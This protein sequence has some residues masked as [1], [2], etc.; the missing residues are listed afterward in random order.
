MK[1]LLKEFEDLKTAQFI[2]I[3]E[4]HSKTTGEVAN[5]VLNAGFKYANA[6]QKDLKA[7]QSATNEDIKAIASDIFDVELVKKAI[8]K[9]TASLVK[10]QNSETQSNQ[11]KAQQDAYF[12]ITNG[13]KLHKETLKVHVYALHVSKKVI[14]PGEYKK[15]NSRELTLAQNAVK[16]YFNFSTSKY[17]Q[18]IVD[19]KHLTSKINISGNSYEI[20]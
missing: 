2:G 17:R 5:H 8:E 16:K 6:V 20:L 9:L 3:K 14:T 11:S 13:I 1:T 19:K 18:F 4:Y 12:H 10:N 15:V 7:L